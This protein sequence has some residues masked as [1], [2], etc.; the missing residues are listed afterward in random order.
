MAWLLLHKCNVYQPEPRPYGLAKNDDPAQGPLT[1]AICPSCREQLIIIGHEFF[2]AAKP[3]WQ[4]DAKAPPGFTVI[5]G[6][7]AD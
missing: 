5:A 1:Q 6:K 2:E 4:M 7:K 3:N